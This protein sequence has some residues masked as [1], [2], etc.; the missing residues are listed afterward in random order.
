[1]DSDEYE[2]KASTNRLDAASTVADAD[3]DV[4]RVEWTPGF[5]NA[6]SII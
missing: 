6:F 5:G 1:M 4:Q 2:D 3:K